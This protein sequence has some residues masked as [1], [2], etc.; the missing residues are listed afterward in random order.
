MVWDMIFIV[1]YVE[2]IIFQNICIIS[3]IL[4]VSEDNITCSSV[5]KDLYI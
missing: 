4:T 2:G 1:L 5:L 3:L